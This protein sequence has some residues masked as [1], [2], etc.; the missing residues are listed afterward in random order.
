MNYASLV[1]STLTTVIK[2]HPDFVRISPRIIMYAPVD[3]FTKYVV[4]H[5]R[6]ASRYF[7]VEWCVNF[8]CEPQSRHDYHL[9]RIFCRLGRSTRFKLKGTGGI[10]EVDDPTMAQD[11]ADQIGSEILPIFRSLDTF[12]KMSEF[13]SSYSGPFA[14][15]REAWETIVT[16]AMGDIPKA[17]KIWRSA[18]TDTRRWRVPR[19]FDGNPDLEEWCRLEAPLMAGDRSALIKLLHEWEYFQVKGTKIERHWKST[20]F[21]IESPT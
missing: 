13:V 2:C 15:S 19:M 18:D 1:R 17:Q 11:F 4:I 5:N 6:T 14:G 3:H 16:V 9:G 7:I 21:P 12:E 10:F 20:P 8:L